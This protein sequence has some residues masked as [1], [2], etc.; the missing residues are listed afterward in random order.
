MEDG[1]GK[2]RA[3]LTLT[4]Q[5]PLSFHELKEYSDFAYRPTAIVYGIGTLFFGLASFGYAA[6]NH[7]QLSS[8][9]YTILALG[10]LCFLS[11]LYQ[12]FLQPFLY[13]NRRKKEEDFCLTIQDGA[14]TLVRS[15]TKKG[16]EKTTYRTEFTADDV[17]EGRETEA[18][19]IL[20]Y[21]EDDSRTRSLYIL[22]RDLGPQ[23]P[24]FETFWS[25]H[26]GFPKKYRG[27]K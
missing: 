10:I 3:D 14:F 25:S 19:F 12:A 6:L 7:Y 17:L 5:S 9:F 22:K 18:G 15:R 16:G 27:G 23:L 11:F 1:I 8:S 13:Q 4:K 2:A 24:A 21:R 26:G 20:L